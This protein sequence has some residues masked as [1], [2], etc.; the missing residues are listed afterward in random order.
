MTL[1]SINNFA[2]NWI[3]RRIFLCHFLFVY[4]LLLFAFLDGN[5]R[6]V[7]QWILH[8][9]SNDPHI[10]YIVEKIKQS[11][12][13]P[14]INQQRSPNIF[15]IFWYWKGLIYWAGSSQT[16]PLL[17]QICNP[18][19]IFSSTS[20][21]ELFTHACYRKTVIKSEKEGTKWLDLDENP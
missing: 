7:A 19:D 17:V 14:S 11:V 4:P 21:H 16:G 15:R 9:T 10:E 5:K 3:W 13:G 20:V 1:P 12:R 18:A 2:K 6:N 8:L